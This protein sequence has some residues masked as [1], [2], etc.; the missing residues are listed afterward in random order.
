MVR[1]DFTGRIYHEG[2]VLPLSR[3]TQIAD[4]ELEGPAADSSDD[5]LGVGGPCEGPWGL[6]VLSDV[7]VELKSWSFKTRLFGPGGRWSA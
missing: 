4:F 6:V 7:P 1:A 5:G 3:C 2:K